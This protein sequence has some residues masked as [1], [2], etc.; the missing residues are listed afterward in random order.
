MV[1]KE[2]YS[3]RKDGVSLFRTYSDK[4]MQIHKLG[5]DEYY[6]EAIDVQ[7][8]GFIYEETDIP[9]EQATEDDVPIE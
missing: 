2:F 5:T 7:G 3:M 8:C 1:I 6:E 4:A 9:I